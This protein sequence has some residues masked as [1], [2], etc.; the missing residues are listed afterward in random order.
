[1][2]L[3]DKNQ[4]PESYLNSGSLHPINQ[5]KDYLVGILMDMGFSEETGP[6]IETEENNFDLLNIEKS[7]PARQCMILFM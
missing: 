2:S 7:H 4:L 5:I 3:F 1:M 6:E